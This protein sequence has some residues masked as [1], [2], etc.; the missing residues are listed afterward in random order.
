MEKLDLKN[1]KNCLALKSKVKQ[2]FMRGRKFVEEKYTW[3][4]VC[5]GTIQGYQENLK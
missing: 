3:E 5:G 2:I 1:Y 4:V